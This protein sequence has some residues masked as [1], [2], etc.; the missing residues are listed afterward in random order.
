MC[1]DDACPA[2]LGH[3]WFYRDRGNYGGKSRTECADCGG[4]GKAKE[5][6]RAR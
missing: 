1:N 4:S 5:E 6:S 3:G 2:C